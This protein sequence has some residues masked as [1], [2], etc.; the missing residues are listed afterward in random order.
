MCYEQI[1]HGILN[2]IDRYCCQSF[3]TIK[4]NWGNCSKIQKYFM[5][6]DIK[7]LCYCGN[8]NLNTYIWKQF[9]LLQIIF[10]LFVSREEKQN[11]SGFSSSDPISKA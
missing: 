9:L 3:I 10:L 8:I 7:N 2:E 11:K 6:I 4:G 1:V 5:A